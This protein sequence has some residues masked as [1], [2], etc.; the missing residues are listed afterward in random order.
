MRSYHDWHHEGMETNVHT[1]YRVQYTMYMNELSDEGHY[2]K[3]TG[4]NVLII[5]PASANEDISL[6]IIPLS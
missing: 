1:L 4:P 6:G 2:W 5:W 3:E